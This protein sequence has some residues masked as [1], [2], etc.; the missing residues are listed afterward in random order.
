VIAHLG[1]RQG[2]TQVE[3]G[4]LR[5]GRQHLLIELVEADDED[6]AFHG[7]DMTLGGGQFAS[8][9]PDAPCPRVRVWVRLMVPRWPYTGGA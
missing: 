8:S 3:P 4:R 5:Q 9:A 7:H 1:Q 6:W 2:R